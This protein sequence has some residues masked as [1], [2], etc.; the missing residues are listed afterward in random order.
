MLLSPL[1][2]HGGVTATSSIHAKRLLYH[3]LPG[4]ND[5]MLQVHANTSGTSLHV[6]PDTSTQTVR[7][8]VII[9]A[10]TGS[11]ALGTNISW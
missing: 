6:I 9:I 1:Y 10:T 11:G 2:G 3:T 8:V 5:G 4:L 7:I